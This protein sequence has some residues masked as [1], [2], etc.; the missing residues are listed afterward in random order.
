M[1]TFKRIN[2]A[3]GTGRHPLQRDVLLSSEVSS[4]HRRSPRSQPVSLESFVELSEFKEIIM[5]E[6]F[7]NIEAMPFEEFVDF[8]CLQPV[9]TDVLSEKLF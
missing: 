6:M 5:D 7:D 9:T 4:I 1:R 3:K 2:D 8:Y